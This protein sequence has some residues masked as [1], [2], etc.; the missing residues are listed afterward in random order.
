M[1]KC[2]FRWIWFFWANPMEWAQNAFLINEFS[3]G[4]WQYVPAPVNAEGLPTPGGLG[5]YILNQKSIHTDY[6]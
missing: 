6:W 4:H 2:C 1:A 5:V 3:A